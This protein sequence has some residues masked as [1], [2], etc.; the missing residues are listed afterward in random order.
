MNVDFLN[1]IHGFQ[2]AEFHSELAQSP[3]KL[4]VMHALRDDGLPRREDETPPD[5][6]ERIVEFFEYRIA[7]LTKAGVERS[8]LI[9]DPGMG[10]FLGRS[11]DASFMVLRRIAELKEAFALPV[12]VSVSRKSFL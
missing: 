5:L 8:R 12:L 11:R 3:A 4:I 6:F 1:D 2:K 10:L 7:A 9:L